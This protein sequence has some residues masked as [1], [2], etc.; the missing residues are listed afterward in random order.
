MLVGASNA[1]AESAG[2]VRAVTNSSAL[3]GASSASESS[4]SPFFF[5]PFFFLFFNTATFPDFFFPGFF[6]C[7]FP[8]L[9]PRLFRG[10]RGEEAADDRGEDFADDKALSFFRSFSTTA[11]AASALA[12]A[13]L[14]TSL[15][16]FPSRSI[17]P[18]LMANSIAHR[19]SFAASFG[20]IPNVMSSACVSTNV[21]I[22]IEPIFPWSINAR[23]ACGE[24][25]PSSRSQRRRIYSTLAFLGCG[26][27]SKSGD[28]ASFKT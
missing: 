26:V 11:C 23:S 1:S 15:P 17:V 10:V 8:F 4:G 3:L 7:C 13:S 6:F 2:L 12:T 5:F 20:F 25:S 14:S 27:C 16:S 19:C 9:P 24:A 22:S 21:N 18:F 28:H